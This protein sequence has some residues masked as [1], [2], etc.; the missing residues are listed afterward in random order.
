MNTQGIAVERR[1]PRRIFASFHAA[2]S[3]GALA[4][5]VGRAGAGMSRAGVSPEPR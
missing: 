3:F 1:H 4:G 2:F 5:A